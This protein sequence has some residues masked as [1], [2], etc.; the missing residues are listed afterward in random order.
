[1]LNW[2]EDSRHMDGN[3]HIRELLRSRDREEAYS[4]KLDSGRKS[5]VRQKLQTITSNRDHMVKQRVSLL[6][7]FKNELVKKQRAKSERIQSERNYRIQTQL[8][9]RDADPANFSH[10][11]MTSRCLLAEKKKFSRMKEERE[12]SSR[13]KTMASESQLDN[14]PKQS[15]AY[16]MIEDFER[17]FRV[18]SHRDYAGKYLSSRTI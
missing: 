2:K 5:Q 9:E 12:A 18:V 16:S 13:L 11:D 15:Q 14:L 6:E 17:S 8:Y 3:Q 7:K 4:P 1:M 10:L